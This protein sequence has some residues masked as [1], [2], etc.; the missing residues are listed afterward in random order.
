MKPKVLF[1]DIETAPAKVFVWQLWDVNV[2]TNQ[3]IEDGYIMC[4]SAKWAGETKIH[5]D[6]VANHCKPK[7]YAVKGEREIA[8]SIW[9]LMDEADIVV[10]HNGDQFDLKWINGVFVKHGIPPVSTFKSVDTLKEAKKSGRFISNKM[11]FLTRKFKVGGKVETGG[12]ALW[13]KCMNGGR[14][15][16]RRMIS[17]CKHDTRLLERLYNVL[18]PYMKSHPNLGLF[19]KEGD[20]ICPNCGSHKI[21]KKGFFYTNNGKYQRYRCLNCGKNIRDTHRLSKTDLVSI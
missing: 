14:N 21:Q 18:L 12:F 10:T 6:S 7:D 5:T 19:S 16:W 15:A 9:K 1:L 11:D 8:K 13:V 2:G 3:I 4:W 20:Q 17:Y